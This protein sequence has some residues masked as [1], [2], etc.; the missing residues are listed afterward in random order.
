MSSTA[1]II[2][3]IISGIVFIYSNALYYLKM[4][5]QEYPNAIISTGPRKYA[6]RN[7]EREL[8]E[9]DFESSD[10]KR[11]VLVFLTTFLEKK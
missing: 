10:A 4:Q 5:N 1:T 3:A 7:K 11:Q 6:I 2:I 8:V 9:I